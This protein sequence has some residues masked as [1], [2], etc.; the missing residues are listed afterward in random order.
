MWVNSGDRV[1]ATATVDLGGGNYG[2]TSEFAANVTATSTGIIV[3]DTTS[4]VADGTTTSS[5]TNLGNAAAPTAASRCARRSPPPTTPPT[6]ARRTRSSSP[7]PLTDANHVYYRDNGVAGTFST[8]V[9]TTL[10]DAQISDFDADYL[11]GTARSWY[12]ISLSGNYLDVTQAVIIDGSTQA[13]YSVAAGPVIEINAAGITTAGDENAIALTTGASTIRGLVINSAGDNAIEID[14]NADNSVIVG[15]YLGT[16]VSGTQARGNATLAVFGALA[17]K[18]DGVVI[19]GT[20][21]ADRNVI[22]GNIYYGIEIY[23]SASGSSIHGNYIGTRAD[24]SGTLGNG[25]SGIYIQ[26]GAFNNTIGGTAANEGNLIAGNGG[27]G[28]WVGAT[29]G[30]GNAILGNAIYS[31]TGLAIDLG[32][33]GVTANDTN[34]GDSGANDLLNFP[35]V[36]KVVQN[37]ANLDV[38][39]VLDVPAGNYRIELYQNPAG[40]DP[41]R[42]GEGQVFLGALSITSTGGRA[43]LYRD[44]DQRHGDLHHAHQRHR[45]A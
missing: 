30:A 8:A 3:V 26:G 28:V 33:N 4:D 18:A 27:D 24:G 25:L 6:A 20:T 21:A 13:G 10:A 23:S 37:G 41:T 42:Y 14:V 40:I 43:D 39:L 16:D 38:T 45:H 44:A 17:V 36:T 34:D 15:N 9:T 22:S 1:T 35:I 2:S 7:F 11:A 19:G 32:A 31:N 29:A 5:I 12:R